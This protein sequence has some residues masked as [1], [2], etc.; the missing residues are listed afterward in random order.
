[1]SSVKVIAS[2]ADVTHW[3]NM[4]GDILADP[5]FRY[6]ILGKAEGA[7][8]FDL[9][10]TNKQVKNVT[11]Q[12]GSVKKGTF[13]MKFGKLGHYVAYEMK[14]KKIQIFDSSHSTGDER[15]K[16][17]D[18]FPPF[19]PTIEKNFSPNVEFIETFGTPQ[20]LN[21]DSFCQTWSL[22]YLMGTPTHKIMKKMK[23]DNKIEVLYKL[24]KYIIGLPMF[25]KICKEETK[26]IN[27]NFKANKAPKKWDPEY[28]LM[29]SREILDL[30]SFH[31]LFN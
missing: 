14:N 13:Y 23:S 26:W 17:S 15:G 31:Y 12:G 30:E 7:G 6:W 16:Y 21:G 3:K 2:E 9:I 20:T 11:P 18:C 24:C 29:F 22:A 1:M 5:D 4:W 8:Y 27:K 28:F 10:K 19:I 25:K